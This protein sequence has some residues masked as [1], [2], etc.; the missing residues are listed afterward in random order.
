M[1]YLFSSELR[2]SDFD[3]IPLT[4]RSVYYKEK[5]FAL[6]NNYKKFIFD[7]HIAKYTGFKKPYMIT[8]CDH[9]F[10]TQCLESWLNQKKECPCCRKEI[11]EYE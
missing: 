2:N 3:L 6:I 9:Y 11:K 7:F 4:S 5:F 8:P 1:H 10:H